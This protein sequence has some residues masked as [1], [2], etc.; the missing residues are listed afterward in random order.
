MKLTNLPNFTNVQLSNNEIF[1]HFANSLSSFSSPIETVLR[2]KR[3]IVTCQSTPKKR[4]LIPVFRSTL[5]A[6]TRY[7]RRQP[8][9]SRCRLY[10]ATMFLTL[11]CTF[12]S[13]AAI[14]SQLLLRR[15]PPQQL[16]LFVAENRSFSRFFRSCQVPRC[17]MRSTHLCS[18][19]LPMATTNGVT[20][21]LCPLPG[22]FFRQ[23]CGAIGRNPPQDWFICHKIGRLLPYCRRV[24]HFCQRR[25]NKKANPI[26]SCLYFAL[27][28]LHF[29]LG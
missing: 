1:A 25:R 29:V 17:T 27:C 21:L 15:L 19:P 5:T 20:A 23:P 8:A 10:C 3:C 26:R 12:P 6:T 24:R 9:A 2:E 22:T 14:P 11:F 16:R 13:S 18:T 28:T 4:I 7:R